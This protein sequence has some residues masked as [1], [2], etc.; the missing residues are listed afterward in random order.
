MYLCSI[1]YNAMY[2]IK[3]FGIYALVFTGL[4]ILTFFLLLYNNSELSF[5]LSNTD[6]F[7]QALTV[8]FLL[9]NTIGFSVV[10]SSSWIKSNFSMFYTKQKQFWIHYMILALII[11]LINIGIFIII[12]LIAHIPQPFIIKARGMTN[13]VIIWMVEMIIISLLL[14]VTSM[15]SSLKLY[16]EK[17]QYEN[18]SMKARYVALQNQMNPHFLFNSLNT[19]ISEIEYDPENAVRFTRNLSDVYRYVLT[20]QN[21]D[22]VYLSDEISF[23]K[24][25]IYL[26]K[27]RLGDCLNIHSNVETVNTDFKIPPL[28]LQILAE[29]VFKHNKVG[30]TNPIDIEILIDSNNKTLKF[31]NTK[32][33]KI[34]DSKLKSGTGLKNLAERYKLLCNKNIEISESENTFT[35]IIP[36]I[37]E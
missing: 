23:L 25:Y 27:V 36:L 28:A 15:S 26:H 7:I 34:L 1:K 6:N 11:L 30:E 24:S 21:A 22:T 16:K 33:P 9:F 35:V 19:L 20:N 3:S 13:I 4:A 5:K 10:V 17:K 37:L 8:T 29:N 32:R 2:K 14:S 31:T 12:K 18:E